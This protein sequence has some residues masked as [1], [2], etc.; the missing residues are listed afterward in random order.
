MYVVLRFFFFLWCCLNVC[1][2]FALILRILRL[3]KCVCIGCVS[4]SNCVY[5]LWCACFSSYSSDVVRICVYWLC[6][7]FLCWLLA[8]LLL[9]LIVFTCLYIVRVS[10]SS[11]DSVS[12]I[13][14]R[15]RLLFFWCCLNVCVSL[16]VIMFLLLLFKCL[17]IVC[18]SYSYSSDVV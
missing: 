16:A 3:F 17:C 9:L 6:F 4:S 11:C 5:L 1:V 7:F 18:V 15:M 14:H 8:F 10:S 2:L 12:R 13:V